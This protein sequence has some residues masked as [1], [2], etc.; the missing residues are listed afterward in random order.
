M[1]KKV[2]PVFLTSA[3]LLLILN[4][5]LYAQNAGARF[6]LWKPSAKSMALGGSGAARFDG[7]SSVYFN[8]ALLSKTESFNLSASYVK[9]LPF[10]DNM[11]AR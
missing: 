2:I 6:L 8:P 7:A 1:I 11:H 3:V 10:F 4:T 5:N 9:P